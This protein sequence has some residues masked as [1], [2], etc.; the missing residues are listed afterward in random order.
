MIEA[1]DQ[2]TPPPPERRWPPAAEVPLWADLSRLRDE[3]PLP[4]GPR[5]AA[6]DTAARERLR[7]LF[8]ELEFRS[9]AD[10]IDPAFAGGAI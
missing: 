5:W 6:V 10:R 2:V 4:E 8:E 9:L 1:L 7:A 3:V